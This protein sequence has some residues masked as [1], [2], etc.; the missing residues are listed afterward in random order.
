MGGKE[1]FY[2]TKLCR[3]PIRHGDEVYEI[4]CYRMEKIT[5]VAAPPEIKSYR[6][7]CKKLKVGAA[8]VRR[9]NSI[10]LL[11]SM[12]QNFLHPK[13]VKQMDGITIVRWSFGDGYWR[14]RSKFSV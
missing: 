3:V 13:P 6:K 12:R 5:S 11:I 10:D 14:I 8:K 1:E 7:L 4:P 2:K 9:P